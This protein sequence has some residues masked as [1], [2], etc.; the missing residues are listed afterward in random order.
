MTWSVDDVPLEHLKKSTK[1]HGHAAPPGTGPE[2]E[3]CGTCKH[4]A[5][6]EMASRFYKCS[7]MQAH[8]TGGIGTDVRVRDAACA[9]WER[10]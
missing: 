1:R 5:C 2:G 9:K 7:L 8:W 3:T 10:R 6:K 4:L